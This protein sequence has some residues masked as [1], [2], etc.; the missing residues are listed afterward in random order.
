M[1]KYTDRFPFISNKISAYA[2][3]GGDYPAEPSNTLTTDALPAGT[4]MVGYSFEIDF[5]GNKDKPLL[6]RMTG[7]YAGEEFVESVPAASTHGFKSRFYLFPKIVTEGEVITHGLEFQDESSA[8]II[9][10]WCDV[11]IYRVA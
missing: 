2:P 10:D 9:I 6:F 1:V 8:G 4:Y 11:M 5:Q 7:T 3:P